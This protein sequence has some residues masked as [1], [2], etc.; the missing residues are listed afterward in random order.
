MSV[1][2]KTPVRSVQPEPH[3]P[4]VFL[5]SNCLFSLLHS[6]YKFPLAMLYLEL[7]PIFLPHTVKSHSSDSYTYL[8][9]PELIVCLTI[10]LSVSVLSFGPSCRSPTPTMASKA[11]SCSQFTNWPWD[12]LSFDRGLSGVNMYEYHYSLDFP[13]SCN[14][15]SRPWIL[16]VRYNSRGKIALHCGNIASLKIL[17]ITLFRWFSFI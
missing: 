9:A 10:L 4:L 1:F 17:S 6:G 5:L 12:M 11:T 8:I 14:L 13:Q 16:S 15:T 7:K 3:F 2:S